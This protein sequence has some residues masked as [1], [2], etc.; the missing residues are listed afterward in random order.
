MLVCLSGTGLY[1]DQVSTDVGL[2]MGT[3]PMFWAQWH[4]STSTY[5]QSSF[6]SSTWKTGGGVWMCELGVMYLNWY[7]RGVTS[8]VCCVITEQTA[9]LAFCT[10]D[11]VSWK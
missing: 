5:S 3:T 7:C 9:S 6:S 4:Q 11:I 8:L 10:S 1:Y 2:W